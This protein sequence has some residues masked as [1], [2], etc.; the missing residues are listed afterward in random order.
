M[1]QY[2]TL[3]MDK[4]VDSNETVISRLYKAVEENSSSSS[5]SSSKDSSSSSDKKKKKSKKKKSKKA[6]GGKKKG[7]KAGIMVFRSDTCRVQTYDFN[8]YPESS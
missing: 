7:N 3:N 4:V 1:R 5:S 2:L 6:S 8:M